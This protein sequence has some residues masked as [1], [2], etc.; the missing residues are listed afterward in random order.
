MQSTRIAPAL[1]IVL[2]AALP[3]AAQNASAPELRDAEAAMAAADAAQAQVF[4]KSL[5]DEANYR[6]RFARD[7]WNA[8][9]LEKRGAA[10][11]AAVE[12]AAAFR[13]ANA[14]ARWLGTNAAIK[15]LQMD[16][17]RFG[18]T[19]NVS[20]PDEPPNADL[21]HGATTKDHIAA[22]ERAINMAK[23][24][25]ADQSVVDNELQ[26]ARDMVASAK[27]IA[28]ADANNEIADSL[29]Y[30]AE[31]VARRAYYLGQLAAANRVLPGVQVERTRLAQAATEQQAAAERAQRLEAERRS[32][33]LQRQLA[34]EQANRQT[35]AAE[36]DRLR[37]QI[38][39][40]RRAAQTRIDA[41][42]AA[43]AAAEQRLDDL[44]RSYEAALANGSP[45]DVESLRRQIED[46]TLTL[47]SIQE[48]ERLQQE[49]MSGDITQLRNDLNA[50]QS[51][52]SMSPQAL[53]ERQAELIR[54]Q[55]ELDQYRTEREAD[56]ERRRQSDQQY[57]TAVGEAMRRRQEAEAQAAA[58][59][60]QAAEAQRL[61]Q[62]AQ[63][64]A[65]S[66]QADK[67]AAE[68]Q[69]QAAQA[70]KLAAQQQMQQMQQQNQ[71]MQQ[72]TQQQVEQLQQQTRQQVEQASAAAQQAQA[73]ANA[74]AAE[75]ERTRQQLAERDA[76]A[77]RLRLEQ[78]L[79][80][81][82]STRS[83]KR[84]VVVTLPAAFFDTG[85]AVLKPTA[86]ATLKKIAKQLGSDG[87]LKISVEGHTDNV[88]SE[89]KNQQ[90]SEKRANAVRN[91]L[92][93]NGVGA[94]RIS[95]SGKGK[96]EPIAPNKT[97]AG[98]Q[99][100]RRVEIIIAQ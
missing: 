31:M 38:D 86:K 80:K 20:L 14:K 28:K 70:E 87:T 74:T 69:A 46:Q 76:E 52:S 19:T 39:E 34:A 73:S 50:A 83:D 89:A 22:A 90:L 36:L 98:R 1:L 63:Q 65:Q 42:R 48:R 45:S 27:R 18:G 81:F 51:A 23:A 55:T 54:R 66:A 17:A 41:D 68:Q 2:L 93:A 9:K 94:D 88:G 26:L 57:Q 75:L 35:Q 85:K 82:A 71:Q 53:S 25:G 72:Q 7:N 62:E 10:A 99:Q 15:G 6:L 49:A 43:R 11:R 64:Q 4:A 77:R 32:A 21:M 16:I 79:S 97:A 30:R 47:R 96:D 78:E 61:A 58:F 44:Y 60:Q 91:Y 100:N 56:L 84:G 67:Q 12:A 3:L 5:Y 40:S 59:R 24:V 29:A 13:A 95:A 33:E 8:N 92:V 37:Q